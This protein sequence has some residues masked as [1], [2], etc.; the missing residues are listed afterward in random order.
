MST[1]NPLISGAASMDAVAGNTLWQGFGGQCEA[2]VDG[3]PIVQYDKAANRLVLTQFA[4]SGG[5][6]GS[7]T[8]SPAAAL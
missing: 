1:A 8:L 4:V 6:G 2:Q 7:R 5:N 3:D